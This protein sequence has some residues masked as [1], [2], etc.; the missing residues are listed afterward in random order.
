MSSERHRRPT[1]DDKWT[2][3][4]TFSS[5]SVLSR[6]W[7]L[8]SGKDHVV[9]TYGYMATECYTSL[10]KWTYGHIPRKT[11][12]EVLMIFLMLCIYSPPGLTLP[13]A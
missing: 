10:V 12:L 5:D 6:A 1:T 8:W 7:L 13:G 4:G 2:P 3:V 11:T 9:Y